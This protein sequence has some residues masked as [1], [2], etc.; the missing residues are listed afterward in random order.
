MG[1]LKLT[2]WACATGDRAGRQASSSAANWSGLWLLAAIGG[3]IVGW[4]KALSPSRFADPAFV[5]CSDE[6]LLVTALVRP[7]CSGRHE[8]LLLLSFDGADRLMA[9]RES[10]EASRVRANMTPAMVR[11]AVAT[12]P[13]G[14]ILIAHNHPSG[15]A[16]PS[17]ED[18][19]LTR[20]IAMLCQL[21]AIRLTD[22]LV[23]TT[24]GHFS[25]RAAG[26]V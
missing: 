3:G 11:A 14:S 1:G 18:I 16:R 10:R 23:L 26:L 13:G 9:A 24:D 7:H 6:S 25:F 4:K 12:P 22:H 19:A 2:G 17:R 5:S 21:A 15:D 8:T 20:Q